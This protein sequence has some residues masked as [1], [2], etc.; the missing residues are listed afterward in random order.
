[1]KKVVCFLFPS[2]Q[3]K[4]THGCYVAVI[5]TLQSCDHFFVKQNPRLALV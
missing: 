1:M 4:I 2:R 5:T 3:F